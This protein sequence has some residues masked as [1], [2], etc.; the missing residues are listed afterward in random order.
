M[1]QFGFSTNL[2]VWN[3]VVPKR[4][5][6]IIVTPLFF[7]NMLQ[8]C[9]GDAAA[10]FSPIPE[11]YIQRYCRIVFEFSAEMDE[12]KNSLLTAALS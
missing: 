6:L 11:Y 10:L 9:F 7:I 2:V 4:S 8:H 3:K 12:Q 5:K 1:M